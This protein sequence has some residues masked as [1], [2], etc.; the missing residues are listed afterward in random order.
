MARVQATDVSEH[1]ETTCDLEDHVRR[2]LYALSDAGLGLECPI[3][4]KALV[5]IAETGRRIHGHYRKDVND[6]VALVTALALEARER[7]ATQAAIDSQQ[8]WPAV[9]DGKVH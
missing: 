2:I 9:D 1:S 5:G 8:V 6:V 4:Y 3:V 7:K